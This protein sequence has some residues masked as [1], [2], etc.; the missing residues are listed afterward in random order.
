[1][2]SQPEPS[3]RRR[4]PVMEAGSS[5]SELA[6]IGGITPELLSFKGR[7]EASPCEHL[8]AH[9]ALGILDDE[10]PLGPLEM[11]TMKAMTPTT[12]TAISEDHAGAPARRCRPNSRVPMRAVRQP[13]DDAAEDDERDA[14]AD[15]ALGDLLAQPHQEDGPAGQRHDGGDAEEAARRRADGPL[16]RPRGRSAMPKACDRR[17]ERPSDSACT[18]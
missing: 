7:W 1:M 16:A 6:K 13:R 11:K 9:L 14:V 15:A 17:Q 10:P 2:R 4:R 8:V 12:T 18:G 5:S 3:P